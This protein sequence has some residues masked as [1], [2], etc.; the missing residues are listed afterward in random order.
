MKSKTRPISPRRR[1]RSY[2]QRCRCCGGQSKPFRQLVEN[3]RPPDY[4]PTLGAIVKAIQG[5]EKRLAGIE[6]H[7]AIKLTPEQHGRAI[8]RA[9]PRTSCARRWRRFA[10]RPPR[11]AM[12]GDNW[13][14]SSARRSQRKRSGAGSY[15]LRRRHRFRAHVVSADRGPR[16]R[17]QLPRGAGGAARPIDGRPAAR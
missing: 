6:G 15:G 17:R 5:V 12:S 1:S 11:S 14:R 4:A 13:A 3:S 9:G 7:P 10:M 8:E 2:E 16:A